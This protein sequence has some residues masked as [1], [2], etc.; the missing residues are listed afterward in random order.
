MDVLKITE[1]YPGHFQTLL[2][3]PTAMDLHKLIRPDYK[4]IWGV[5]HEE[6]GVEWGAYR[7]AVFG[8][9]LDQALARNIS[10]EFLLETDQFLRVLPG[11]TQSVKIVQTNHMPPYYLRLSTITQLK[12]WY[13]LLHK[14]VDYL[15][16]VDI[17]GASDYAPMISPNRLFLESVIQRLRVH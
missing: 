3:F 8:Q 5:V 17:P 4:Y 7:G 11:I 13:D 15:F 1:I 16:E 14:T 6:S 10:F 12:T 2:D 9:Y